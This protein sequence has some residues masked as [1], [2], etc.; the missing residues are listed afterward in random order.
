MRTARFT[1]SQMVAVL[2]EGASK[3]LLVLRSRLAAPDRLRRGPKRGVSA[4]ARARLPGCLR[5]LRPSEPAGT[6]IGFPGRVNEPLRPV[7]SQFES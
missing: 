5:T 2:K 1:E 7:V 4:A 3:N 6:L